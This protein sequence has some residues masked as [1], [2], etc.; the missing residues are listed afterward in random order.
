MLRTISFALA[1]SPSRS[2]N[3]PVIVSLA[4]FSSFCLP[5]RTPAAQ[6]HGTPQPRGQVLHQ[7]ATDAFARLINSHEPK[8]CAGFQVR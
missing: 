7:L 8:T 6:V 2:L 5:A 1:I 3:A 4:I